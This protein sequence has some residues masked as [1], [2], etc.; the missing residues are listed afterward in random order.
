MT[1]YLITNT[2]NGKQ[3]VGITTRK[4]KF[5]WYEH[6]RDAKWHRR[7]TL[8]AKAIRK[9]GADAFTIQALIELR[10][11][12]GEGYTV[13]NLKE[14]EKFVVKSLRSCGTLYNRTDGGDT[15][16]KGHS[17]HI[18][19]KGQQFH[20]WT[21]IEPVKQKSFAGHQK[22]LCRCHCG[23][24]RAISS[25]ALLHGRSK[26]CGCW[27]RESTAQRARK[28]AKLTDSQARD[29]RR[30]YNPPAVTAPDLAAEYKVTR[31]AIYDILKG[32][33]HKGEIEC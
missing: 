21:V 24:E 13:E 20:R 11:S 29:I 9:Y 30:R 33:N 14:W 4:V 2:M 16:V 5:R 22:W 32:K 7:P 10:E 23:T 28:K 27:R 19:L 15:V 31:N 1:V 18:D 25:A 6:V 8:L 17:R 12:H 3:Y 26:S